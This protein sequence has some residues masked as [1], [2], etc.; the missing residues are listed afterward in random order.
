MFHIRCDVTL[1][2]LNVSI[3]SS[4]ITKETKN[5]LYK[6]PGTRL[7]NLG[8]TLIPLFSGNS[9]KNKKP[10]INYTVVYNL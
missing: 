8:H 9:N 4:Q 1:N 5:S 7:L 6:C 3:K 10:D 2:F